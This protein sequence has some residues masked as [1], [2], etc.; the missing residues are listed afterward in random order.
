[1]PDKTQPGCAPPSARKATGRSSK[2]S[3]SEQLSFSCLSWQ[4]KISLISLAS[5]LTLPKEFQKNGVSY[6]N[7]YRKWSISNLILWVNCKSGR[8][9]SSALTWNHLKA[10]GSPRMIF[11]SNFPFFDELIPEKQGNL[12]E[13]M[14]QVVMP[15]VP[16]CHLCFNF[17][18]SFLR[19]F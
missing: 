11:T 12:W 19:E 7:L 5:Y 3:D 16:K 14:L 2:G 8:K 18:F 1:M 10:P 17:P 15:E 9:S 6:K 4:Y 13:F